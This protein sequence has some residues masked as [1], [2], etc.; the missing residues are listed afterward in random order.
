VRE[1]RAAGVRAEAYV[2]TGKMGDQFKYADKRGAAIAVLEGPDE[3]SRGE[4]QLKDLVR[5]AELSGTDEALTASHA[6]YVRERKGQI[7]VPRSRMIEGV[8]AI[9]ARRT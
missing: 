2:G 5:G 1:L 9:L 8:R 4:V 3:R 7:T 6:D